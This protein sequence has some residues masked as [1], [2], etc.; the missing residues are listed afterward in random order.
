MGEGGRRGNKDDAITLL[1]A[2]DFHDPRNVGGP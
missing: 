2:G 1:T